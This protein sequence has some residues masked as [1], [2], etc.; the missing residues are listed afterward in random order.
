MT[1]CCTANLDSASLQHSLF[2][3]EQKCM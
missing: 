1:Q 3:T 2:I